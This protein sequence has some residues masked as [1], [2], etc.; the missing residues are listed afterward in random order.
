MLDEGWRNV[1]S[2]VSGYEC[3]VGLDLS[4]WYRFGGAAGE[5]MPTEPPGYESCGTI[6]PGWL[7]TEH[8]R[9]GDAPTEG[10]V[11]WQGPDE[12][13]VCTHRRE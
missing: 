8:P 2:T 4:V 12:T 3:D 13:V 6:M 1:A 9:P 5:R 11:C 7:A 10:T